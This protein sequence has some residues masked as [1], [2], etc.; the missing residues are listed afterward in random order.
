M[1]S[2]AN[3][4]SKE[5]SGGC[6]AETAGWIS[7]TL[8]MPEWDWLQAH[9]ASGHD[10]QPEI[11]IPRC[12]PSSAENIARAPVKSSYLEQ[13][14]H[15]VTGLCTGTQ[16]FGVSLGSGSVW[17]FMHATCLHE[18]DE[19]GERKE[20]LHTYILELSLG[21]QNGPK[22]RALFVCYEHLLMFRFPCHLYMRSQEFRAVLGS[23]TWLK[24]T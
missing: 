19:K 22:L 5:Q 15:E 21:T 24:N 2:V 8:T 1:R 16:K 3:A 17:N 23:S 11:A 18:E 4:T 20:L 14:L 9:A 7:F 6:T 12:S 13:L 10:V